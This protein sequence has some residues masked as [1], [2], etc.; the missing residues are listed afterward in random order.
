MTWRI[1]LAG[2]AIILLLGVM[3]GLGGAVWIVSTPAGTRWSVQQ[4]ERYAG[5]A[6]RLTGLAGAWS[7]GITFAE[8]LYRD[9]SQ[10]ILLTAVSAELNT[11]RLL[12]R[13]LLV[14]RLSIGEL[15]LRFLE[16]PAAAPGGQRGDIV[17]PLEIALA[18]ASVDQ[19]I[20]RG[21]TDTIVEHVE[22]SG[23]WSGQRLSIAQ[24]SGSYQGL[25]AQ[26]DGSIVLS[27]PIGLSAGVA[28]S[29]ELDDGR[30]F[31]GQ[32]DVEGDLSE[33]EFSH[34]LLAPFSVITTG[35]ITLGAEP[36]VDLVS[37]SDAISYT[38]GERTLTF[39][40][41]RLALS[42][43]LDAVDAEL[44]GSLIAQ[45]LPPA[46]ISGVGSGN[47]ESVQLDSLALEFD[48]GRV[49]VSG[50][51]GWAA[52]IQWALDVAITDVDPSQ[53]FP[54]WPG[55]LS[56]VFSVTGSQSADGLAFDAD[57]IA[58]SG[59]LRGQPV[60]LKGRV[61]TDGKRFMLRSVRLASGANYVTVDGTYGGQM[62]LTYDTDI[63]DL[64]I[65][66]EGW[67]GAIAASG[68][69]LGTLSA[70]ELE[71]DATARGLRLPQV[72]IEGM[73]L[74]GRLNPSDP[75]SLLSVVAGGVELP[76]RSIDSIQIEARGVLSAHRLDLNLVAG[77]DALNANISGGWSGQEWRGQLTRGMLTFAQ[78]GTWEQMAEADI[79]VA[80]SQLQVGRL[81]WSDT[82]AM[83]CLEGGVEAE[84]LQFAGQLENLDLRPLQGFLPDGTSVRGA[85]AG[86]FNIT[87]TLESP[88][89]VF[90]ARSESIDLLYRFAADEDAVETSLRDLLITGG[91]DPDR[92]GFE[93]KLTGSQ[94]SSL[95][96]SA[97]LNDWRR[98]EAQVRGRLRASIPDVAFLSLLYTEV[99]DWAGSAE[100]DLSLEGSLR[101][102][103]VAGFLRLQNGRALVRRAGITLTDIRLD[104]LPAAGNRLGIIATARSGEG[105]VRVDGG[106]ELNSEAGWPLYGTVR[107][108]RFT[109]LQ[110][111][112]I[113]V[114]VSPDLAIS[115]ARNTIRL[116]GQVVT[117]RAIVELKELPQQAIE[118][119]PDI[120]V[121]RAAEA[122]SD[123]KKPLQFFTDLK[124]V[125][126][127]EVRFSGF[128]LRA[129][130]AGQLALRSEPSRAMEGRGVVNITS[131]RFQAYGQNLEI[132]N[133]RLL[134]DGPLDDPTLNVEAI[135]RVD[136]VTVGVRVRG[137]GRNP[138]ASIF[139]EPA[140]SETDALSY[141]VIG[142]PLAQAS[143]AEGANLR[144][145]AVALGL[146]QAMPITDQFSEAVG[147]DELGLDPENVDTGAV[148]A[149]KQINS[150]LYVRYSYGLFSRLGALLLRYRL[151]S[152]L[153]LEARSSEDQSLDLIYTRERK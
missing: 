90:A 85:L 141:L 46:R 137:S 60:E 21:E 140:M 128:G 13:E 28:W 97:E 45:D 9:E 41:G 145:S 83:V 79:V 120:T 42:G 138:Q 12:R 119:S 150:D 102:P 34:E 81:C 16:G 135:R 77:A 57:K 89:L 112:G 68:R 126:G 29:T 65:L 70:P 86:E 80:R 114:S 25:D 142:R 61:R 106:I 40:N 109:V 19:L 92:F 24:L 56:G 11:A 22:L 49:Q 91:G 52:A 113:D 149:G 122:V 27:D 63:R 44:D 4:I 53:L 55:A 33:F 132:Q 7:S 67:Q 151:N 152:S 10:E 6:I 82:G 72:T 1:A 26:A 62:A 37:T 93:L 130:L 64:S 101:E 87:G 47:T 71:I 95:A 73:T 111:P 147:L 143:N 148:M 51:L 38:S 75:E 115:G 116:T 121:H 76:Q 2:V 23:M 131:G 139:S 94:E 110:L 58:L 105:E 43:W 107:G 123:V 125:L 5:A 104:A 117:P 59:V 108:E 98:P 69:L 118:V 66:G 84:E 133:G 35:R 36:H 17:T 124:L 78:W 153:S 31:I 15:S 14:E 30:Q 32:A 3:V 48:R 88:A 103:R 127:E 18:R 20:I 54:E 8:V 39:S 100:A 96:L 136:S 129:D 134:F 50:R 146:K 74:S 99:S 144:N